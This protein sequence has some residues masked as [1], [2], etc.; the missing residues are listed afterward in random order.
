MALFNPSKEHNLYSESL[1]PVDY[2]K[3]K[4]KPFGYG[5]IWFGMAVQIT[6]F[7]TFAQM[8]NFFTIGELLWI[9]ILGSILMAIVTLF[10]QD[11]GLR[12]GV[13][14]ATSISASFGYLGGKVAG[15]IRIAPS[16]IFFGVNAYMG[17]VAINEITKMLFNFDHIW[18]AIILN[19]IALVAVTLKGVKGIERFCTFIAPLLL[20]VGVYMM[21]VLLNAYDVSFM[22]TLSMGK[23]GDTTKPWLFGM[24]V[25][26]GG[27]ASV[28]M[29]M[30]DF[31]KDCKVGPEVCQKS[32]VKSN[33]KYFLAAMIGIVPFLVFFTILGNVAIVLSGRTDVLVLI[34]ELIMGK[35]FVLAIVIQLFIVVA[36]LSTNTAANLLPSAYVVCS[37]A[38]K[39]I[40]FKVATIGFAALACVAQPWSYSSQLSTILSVFSA[41][42]GPAMAII[43][44]DYFVFRKRN[45]SFAD[46]FNSHGKYT[47]WK[48][49]NIPA[50]LVY[51]IVTGLS[52]ALSFDYSF[53]I[54]TVLGAVAY[55]LCAKPF[56]KIYPVTVTEDALPPVYED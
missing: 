3:R 40:N 7:A 8:V 53:F 21:Y 6:V 44:V 30:N 52:L 16:L 24:A 18:F 36:Q 31:T 56:A 27:Y 54:G 11:I 2:N 15:I 33:W 13:S 39:K 47:Y 35:S 1:A 14:F 9:Y 43:A 28:A 50:M 29:G 55:Y 10:A 19:V 41:T 17:A 26:V 49:Y 45:L 37:L 23:L 46:L 5:V 25:V 34:N 22:D 20:V 32:W 4:V 48:G 51:V 42:A 12:H 38:P